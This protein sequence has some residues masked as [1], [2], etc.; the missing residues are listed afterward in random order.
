MLLGQKM[1]ENSPKNEGNTELWQIS[2]ASVICTKKATQKMSIRIKILPVFCYNSLNI[3]FK[4]S[5]KPNKI[6]KNCII[7][8]I[9]S[10]N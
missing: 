9:I 8:V 4:I 1:Y 10:L 2:C 5:L 6:E 7:G 3:I